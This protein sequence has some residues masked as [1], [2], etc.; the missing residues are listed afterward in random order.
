MKIPDDEAIPE[1]R[2]KKLFRQMDR[3]RDGRLSLEE[4]VEGA[5]NDPLFC[6]LF[7]ADPLALMFSLS[8]PILIKI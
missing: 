8:V 3:N 5:R 7:Q 2:M 1:K 6:N 4:F